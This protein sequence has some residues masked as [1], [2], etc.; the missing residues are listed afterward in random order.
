[1]IFTSC[2]SNTTTQSSEFFSDFSNEIKSDSIVI[3]TLFDKDDYKVV[4][5]VS[6]SS[7]FVYLDEDNNA[8]GDSHKY[9]KLN[10]SDTIALAKG[11]ALGT[12]VK[13]QTPSYDVALDIA[14]Q[15]ALYA[16]IENAYAMGADTVIEPIYTVETQTEVI[17]TTTTSKNSTSEKKESITKYKVTVRAIAVQIK[18]N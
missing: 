12:G 3:N 17:T 18:N 6:G 14:K 16:L 15:N 10:Q 5:R 4:G 7:D 1:M 11:F 13:R 9:G 2:A 8:V